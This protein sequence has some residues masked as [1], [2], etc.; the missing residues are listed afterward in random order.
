M[1]PDEPFLIPP[2]TVDGEKRRES[3]GKLPSSSLVGNLCME[4]PSLIIKGRPDVDYDL[5]VTLSCAL[6]PRTFA[7][8]GELFRGTCSP[9]V[10]PSD[11][12]HM[13]PVRTHTKYEQGIPTSSLDEP[14]DLSSGPLPDSTSLANQPM[15]FTFCS[16]FSFS[17]PTDVPSGP[18]A[19]TSALTSTS[20]EVELP[21][22]TSPPQSSHSRRRDASYIP[23]PP[24][25]FILFRSSFIRSQQVTGKVEGNHS[26]L[27]K[28]IGPFC[29]IL[30]PLFVTL[31]SLVRHVL[32]DP[33][34][35]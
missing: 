7:N 15:S 5:D 12:P 20:T 8:K 33:P 35:S 30:P 23:R 27:S 3:R 11:D 31:I 22:P 9:S 13:P 4:C 29:P 19:S 34:S 32:E 16:E 25:A 28:I 18:V 21:F 6:R 24:N 26:N 10:S 2:G 17:P 14:P 1:Y